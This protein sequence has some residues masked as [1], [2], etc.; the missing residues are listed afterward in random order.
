[1]EESKLGVVIGESLADDMDGCGEE[2][3]LKRAFAP[4]GEWPKESEII[5]SSNEVVSY[6]DRKAEGI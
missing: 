3:V 1:M 5:R 4:G 6:Y 2:L